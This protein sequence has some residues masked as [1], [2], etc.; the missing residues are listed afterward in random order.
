MYHVSWN[1]Q[2]IQLRKDQSDFVPL[3]FEYGQEIV[4]ISKTKYNL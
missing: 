3:W 4:Y 2:D 1:P